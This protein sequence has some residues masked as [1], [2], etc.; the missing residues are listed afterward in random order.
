V[1]ERAVRLKLKCVEVLK[2]C[3]LSFAVGF[4]LHGVQTVQAQ[5]AFVSTQCLRENALLRAELGS[6]AVGFL[7]L[8][9]PDSRGTAELKSKN[10]AGFFLERQKF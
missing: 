5:Y 4:T 9:S 8:V 3:G 1:K 10:S 6:L 7:Y 2:V